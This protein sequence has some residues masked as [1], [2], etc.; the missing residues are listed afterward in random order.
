MIFITMMIYLYIITKCYLDE[1]AT[2]YL[3][4]GKTTKE[5]K[6]M[7]PYTFNSRTDEYDMQYNWQHYNKSVVKKV[8]DNFEEAKKYTED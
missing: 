5:Y 3:M 8:F 1:E 2:K 7:L 4:N 6:V